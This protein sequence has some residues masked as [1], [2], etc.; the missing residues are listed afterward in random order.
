MA[1]RTGAQALHMGGLGLS[2]GTSLSHKQ[3]QVLPEHKTGRNTGAS[4]SVAQKQKPRTKTNAVSTQK[5]FPLSLPS[6]TKCYLN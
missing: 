6:K 5:P 2:L 3:L 4:P 1:Q